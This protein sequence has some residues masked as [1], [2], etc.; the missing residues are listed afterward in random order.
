MKILFTAIV[1][2]TGTVSAFAAE[3]TNFEIPAS[4]LT[5]AEVRAAISSPNASGVVVIGE[6][7]QFATPS[8]GAVRGDTHAGVT[9]PTASS[10]SLPNTR[11]ASF[12]SNVVPGRA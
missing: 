2:A 1:L 6:A 3:Y 7:T 8:A 10:P 9:M 5:R 4:T 11:S 12:P